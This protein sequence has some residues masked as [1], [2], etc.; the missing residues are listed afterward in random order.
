MIERGEMQITKEVCSE[1]EINQIRQ[2]AYQEFDAF[3]DEFKINQ[4][5]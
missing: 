3:L 1:A 5:R 4:K 2:K